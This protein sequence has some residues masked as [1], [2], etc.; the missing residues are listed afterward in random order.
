MSWELILQ[1][2]NSRLYTDEMI[3]ADMTWKEVEALDR[4][5]I[6]LIPTGSLE[7]HGAHLPLL[8]DSLLA[9]GVCSAVERQVSDKVLMTPCIWLGASGHHMAFAGTCT[10]SMDGYI[11]ALTAVIES[12]AHHRFHRFLVINGHGGNNSPNDV[13]L[14][15]LKEKNPNWTLG[16]IGYYVYGEK[17]IAEV[18]DGPDKGIQHACEAET[19][20]MMHLHPGKVRTSLLRDDGLRTDRPTKS[21]AKMWDEVSEE[22]SLGFA[23]KATPEKGKKIF[24][25]CVEGVVGEVNAIHHGV[26]YVGIF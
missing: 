14:R 9:T 8:T 10:A 2:P 15:S 23:T 1:T 4:N 11:S 3:L 16:H 5:T 20:L 7:Q 17:A 18:M 13:A 12:M 6:V 21:L 19:S 22:G 26:V 24:D 25:A